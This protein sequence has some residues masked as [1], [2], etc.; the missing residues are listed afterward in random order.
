MLT[1]RVT[2]AP[3]VLM[4]DLA[5]EAVLLNLNNE[6]YFGLDEIGTRM[7]EVLQESSSI[8]EASAVLV[9][10]YDVDIERLKADLL[11]FVDELLAYELVEIS[12][13]ET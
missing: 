6:Q 13:G 9:E 2:L 5:G 3:D 8:A 12:E 7:L 1:Q 10:E 4:Q 11:K